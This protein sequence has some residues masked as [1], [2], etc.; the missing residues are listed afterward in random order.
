L[1]AHRV[2][3]YAAHGGEDRGVSANGQYEKEW[4]L[5]L[6]QALQKTLPAY[7]FDVVMIRSRDDS[8]AFDK[9]VSQVNSTIASAVLIIHADREWT[10]RIRGPFAIVEPPTGSV[11]PEGQELQ[12]WGVMPYSQFHQSLRLAKALAQ[13]WEVNSQLSTLSDSRALPGEVPHPDGRVL[14]SPHQFLRYLILPAVVVEPL[15]LTSSQ[16]IKHFSTDAGMQDFADKTARG[17]QTY[18]QM[19]P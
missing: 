8:M 7:G 19:A 6:A 18:F 10:G 12:R 1:A 13:A 11:A 15:F 16:D 3:I 4:T 5:R 17:L 9:W 2:V 14:A